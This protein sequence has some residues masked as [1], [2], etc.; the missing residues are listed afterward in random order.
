MVDFAL[1][2]PQEMLRRTLREFMQRE[3]PPTAVRSAETTERGYDLAIYDRLNDLGVL[4]LGLPEAAGGAGGDWVDLAVFYEEAGRALLASP[5][6]SSV[7][8]GG[9]LLARHGS[10]AQ[11]QAW[12]PDLARGARVLAV[13]WPLGA[14]EAGPS[15][16][17]ARRV[18]SGYV[19]SGEIAHVAHFV[20]A[21]GLLLVAEVMGTAGH[22]GLFLVEPGA[23]GLMATPQPLMSGEPLVRLRLQ[24]TPLAA[25]AAVGDIL[26]PDALWGPL[27]DGAKVALAAY[28]LGAASAAVDMGV[29]YA[30]ERQQ[31]GRPIG[32]FQAV[33]HRL[34]NLQILVE[35]ARLLTYHAAWLLDQGADTRRAAAMA[36]LR[37]SIAVREAA[38]GNILVH[39]GYGFMLEADPQLYYRRAKALELAL[40]NPDAE[41]V[42]LAREHRPLVA[43][44]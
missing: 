14:G 42:L 3:Y 17:E 38:T 19:V 8:L 21:D 12:L 39:G 31:F 27:L 33:Q 24:E 41:R 6:L 15:G 1:S 40:G 4:G 29:A 11:R 34:A 43:A 16:L 32:S 7:V 22:Y 10:P 9:G 20:G 44:K 35:Q 13:G 36:K 23:P 37:A 5:H 2:E 28:A 26:A 18:G 25:E 30:K